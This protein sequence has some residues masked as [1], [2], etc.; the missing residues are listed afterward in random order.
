MNPLEIAGI[1]A[2]AAAVGLLAHV[3]LFAV[4]RRA[5]NSAR[6]A[7]ERSLVAKLDC[8]SRFVMPLLGAELAV[9]ALDLPS[10]YGTVL[11]HALG[12]LLALALAW[13]VI[14]STYV[15]DDVV[16]SRYQMDVADNLRSRRIRTQIQVLRRVTV[17]AV[18]VVTLAVIL[19]S[20]PEVRAAGAGL[21]ASAGLVG[22]VVGVAA[23][24]TAT[25][26]V[27]GLQI[28]MSQP[29]RVDD[30]VVVE[31]EW[32]RI[33]EIGLTYV[34][35]RVWDL[36]R[37]VLP[38]SYFVEQ[39]FENWTRSTADIMGWVYI[40]VDYCASVTEL[41]QAFRDILA[42]SPNWDGK[43]GV[44]QV[45]TLGTE[46]MQLRALM[47]SADSSRSWDLQCEV[48]EQLIAYIQE[49]CA[50][51]LPHLRV[52]SLDGHGDTE[53]QEASHRLRQSPVRHLTGA[54]RPSR[55]FDDRR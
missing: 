27:A 23:R 12:V 32:G 41:R 37:L 10:P 11:V 15:F 25:N 6:A 48:R 36:R 43:V 5:V 47:S 3:V 8:P 40:Q 1:V 18:A 13:L 14:A 26:V 31:D 33:E 50:S 49:H 9:G 34:V 24:P 29:I 17:V 54:A 39:P 45:T 42:G 7:V 38:I 28:A 55:L 20:F 35:V 22:V 52:R 16:L 44:L 2:G 19:L 51:A 21:L 30:V 46:T 53:P 4:F